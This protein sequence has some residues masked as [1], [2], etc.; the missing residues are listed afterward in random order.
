MTINPAEKTAPVTVGVRLRQL[1]KSR[2]LSLAD[3]AEATGISASFLSLVEKERSDITIGRL[4]RV[5][6]FYGISITDL[7][8][9][10][11]AAGYPEVVT[12]PERKLLHSPAEGIDVYLL[13]V[14]TRHQMMPLQL[15]F[16][17]GAE[18]A[19][20]GRH[21]GE[22]WLIVTEGELRLELEGAEPRVLKPGDTAYYPAERPH[23]FSN[24]SATKPLRLICVDTPPTM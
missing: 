16:E 8:P 10:T 21:A 19:E 18:L 13:S 24:A 1:R 20:F 11:I 14:D 22:E 9:G 3:V 6:D 23:L 4:V 7:L 17:P 2:K 15:D 5:I 12:P